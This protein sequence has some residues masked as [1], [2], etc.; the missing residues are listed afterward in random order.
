MWRFHS[1]KNGGLLPWKKSSKY[2][3]LRNL[4]SQCLG[5]QTF[6]YFFFNLCLT[7]TFFNIFLLIYSN[8]LM[9]QKN[10]RF[11]LQT[12][13]FSCLVPLSLY[14]VMASWQP[15]SA[16]QSPSDFFSTQIKAGPYTAWA[17]AFVLTQDSLYEQTRHFTSSHLL[18]FVF[19]RFLNTP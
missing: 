14:P 8:P 11:Y 2:I 7:I 5:E 12:A 4:K 3:I 6:W 18:L 17:H 16:G 10:L 9:L 1:T 19:P 13:V 15:A